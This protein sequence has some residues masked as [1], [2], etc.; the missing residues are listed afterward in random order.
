MCIQRKQVYQLDI[1]SIGYIVV[2]MMI[3]GSRDRARDMKKCAGSRL[4]SS[5]NKTT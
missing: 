3:I 5:R 1:M 4:S 2:E